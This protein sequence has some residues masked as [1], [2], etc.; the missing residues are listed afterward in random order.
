MRTYEQGEDYLI[1]LEAGGIHCMVSHKQ[2]RRGYIFSS[3]LAGEEAGCTCIGD[4][5]ISP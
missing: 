2:F 5:S 1:E 3:M 4:N